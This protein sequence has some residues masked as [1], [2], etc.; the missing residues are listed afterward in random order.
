M[1]QGP[2]NTANPMQP[3]FELDPQS[4]RCPYPAYSTARTEQPVMWAD[5]LQAWVV[6]RYDD[7]VSVLQQPQRFSSKWAS[8][9]GGAT[10][11]AARVA[12]DPSKDEALR[13]MAR[14]RVR[15][16]SSPVL[17]TADPPLHWRQRALVNRAFTP[18]RVA[19]MEQRIRALTDELVG[20]LAGRDEVDIVSGL[21]TPLP[22]GVIADLLAIPRSRMADFKRWSD[23]FVVAV[24]NV[25]LTDDDIAQMLTSMNEF[26]D[27]FAG[28]IVNRQ[29]QPTD[30]LLSAIV[31][32]RLDGEEPL[33]NDEMLNMLVLFLVAGNETTT[34]AITWA[35]LYLLEHPELEQQLRRDPSLINGFVEEVLR[36]EAPVQGLFRTA[37]ED[38]EIGGQRIAAGQ[39]LWMV[40]GSGNHDPVAFADPEQFDVQRHFDKNHLTF[41]FGEH[42]CL[43]ASLARTET[44]VAVEVLLQRF[45]QIRLAASINCH[46][47]FVIHG[48]PELRVRLAP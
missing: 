45:P 32:A 5:R 26:Y 28:E 11:L 31:H 6:S 16:A 19:A 1:V 33:S 46:R 18:R 22:L 7:I 29:Q 14:R 21:S 27:Y 42:Y 41:G 10:S 37:V 2:S 15:I 25:S 8:G 9:P 47:S 24:G 13:E 40:Y 23:S 39:H 17:L 34:N 36:F 35:V 38:V 43:G 12:D 4:V 20:A 3:V 48:I 30:D 44:R